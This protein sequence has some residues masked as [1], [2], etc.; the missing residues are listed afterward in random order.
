MQPCMGWTPVW[1]ADRHGGGSENMRGLACVSTPKGGVLG[2]A[3]EET[4]T[5]R[6]PASLGDVTSDAGLY[7]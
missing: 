6:Q 5:P 2:G 1:E 3:E 4:Q 7:Q